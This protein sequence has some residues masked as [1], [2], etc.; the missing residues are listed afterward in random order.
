[1]VSQFPRP[2]RCCQERRC[3]DNPVCVCRTT[4]PFFCI[5]GCRC[6][7][8]IVDDTRNAQL[9]TANTAA[10]MLGR[11]SALLRLSASSP[12]PVP[13]PRGVFLMDCAVTCCTNIA[14]VQVSLDV[15][16]A[17]ARLGRMKRRVGRRKRRHKSGGGT[18]KVVCMIHTRIL[19]LNC[20]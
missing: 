19:V 15:V 8:R 3:L 18:A 4:M 13:P 6:K 16:R 2:K 11:L 10:S 5:C 7:R 20:H 17:K 9:P 14:D 1:M 12:D